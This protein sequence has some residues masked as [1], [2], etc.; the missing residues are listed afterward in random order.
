MERLEYQDHYYNMRRLPL[1]NEDRLRAWDAA[2]EYLLRQ[3][4]E[5]G[6]AN[7]AQNILLVNDAFGALGVALHTYRATHW[8]D[9]FVAHD[10]L[11]INR[12][13]N[14]LPL[15]DSMMLPADASPIGHFDCALIKLPKNLSFFAD[16]LTRMRNCLRP[17]AQVLT[18]GMIK[19]TPA[20]AYQ[21]LTEIIGPTKTSL[22]WKKARLAISQVGDSI[23]KQDDLK[24]E[25]YDLPDF[26][27]VLKN[28]PNVFS[29]RKLDQGT[30]LLL[31]NLPATDTE[32]SAIDLGCGNG[33][34][35]LALARCC[36]RAHIL[37][38][39][40]SYQAIASANLNVTQMGPDQHRLSFNVADGLHENSAS[41]CDLV[42]CNPPFHQGQTTGDMPAWSMFSEAKRVLRPG[43]R[44]RL[45]GNRHLGYHAKLKRLFSRVEL[46]DSASKFVVL[47]ATKSSSQF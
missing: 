38:V 18:G 11:T 4:E 8:G 22:G 29:S 16:Q 2:D 32:F 23:D 46:I 40:E 24:T 41:S 27:L 14:N 19:H 12:Q 20:R 31:A 5:L 36:P 37:G 3:F 47:E 10:A 28:L 35:A 13:N 9:S 6:L 39:D 17:D 34:L 1:R 7:S 44:L 30:Q 45:V 25:S 43:G 42:I 26:N 33:V 15:L 21:M